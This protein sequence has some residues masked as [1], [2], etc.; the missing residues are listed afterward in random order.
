MNVYLYPSNTETELK[1]A[2]IGGDVLPY[3][4]TSNTMAY[5]PLYNDTLDHSWNNYTLQEE[6]S[7]TATKQNI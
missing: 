7:W 3:T 4:P 5:F 1:N 2:Y 6:A